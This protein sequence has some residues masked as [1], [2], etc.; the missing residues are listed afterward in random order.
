MTI[1][2]DENIPDRPLVGSRLGQA[3]G[4]DHAFGGGGEPYLQPLN[5]LGL[6]DAPAESSL[7]GK[8]SLP[9]RSYP[10]DRRNQ[11]GVQDVIELRASRELPRQMLLQDAHLRLQGAHPPVELALGGECGQVVSQVGLSE[12]PK[13]PLA[14]EAGPL[15]EDSEGENLRIGDQRWTTDYGSIGEVGGCL[16]PILD[17]DVQ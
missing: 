4:C 13:I 7:S 9:A 8:Q 10:H 5:P 15:G 11:G 16:P 6:R 17:E 14:S 2:A 12:P 1:P 3:E